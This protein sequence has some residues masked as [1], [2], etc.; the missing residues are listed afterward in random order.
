MS[1][2][3]ESYSNNWWFC[4]NENISHQINK[5]I[6][7]IY[8]KETSLHLQ[9]TILYTGTEKIHQHVCA[10][11]I[12]IITLNRILWLRIFGLIILRKVWSEY[13]KEQS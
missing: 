9:E 11:K 13:K 10:S 3:I 8:I 4:E 6:T 2:E 5:P 7:L 1:T 12:E